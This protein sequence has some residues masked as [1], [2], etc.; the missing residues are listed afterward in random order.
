MKRL[1][2]LDGL[3][4]VLA[5]YV[6]CSHMAPF[7]LLPAWIAHPLSH[8]GAAVDVFFMLSGLVI[9]ESLH[10]FAYRPRPFLTAR[11]ARLYPVFAVVFGFALAVHAL[12]PALDAMPWLAPEGLAWRMWASG[13]S[14]EWP[15]E[16][17][18]H[19]TMTH[20]LFPDGVMP[21]IWVS[22]LGASWSLSTEWQ[23]YALALLLGGMLARAGREPGQV[24]ARLAWLFVALGAAG[25]LWAWL[26]PPDWHF[27]RAFLGNKAH[28]FA[29]GIASV[30]L[31]R[32]GA[33]GMR[34]YGAV[35]LAALAL[36]L[37][38][39]GPVKLLPP[40][41]WTLCVV[42]EL[43]WLPRLQPLAMLL[44]SPPLQWLGAI[45]YGLYLVN[46][47]LQRLLGTVLVGVVAGDGHLF[48]LLW[49]PLA[50]ILPVLAA[51]WL[52]R[53][54]EVP[55]QRLFDRRRAVAARRVGS[56]DG[57]GAAWATA[58]LR[59]P[60]RRQFEPTPDHA[61]RH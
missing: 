60:G 31:I 51:A 52:H 61:K 33:A 3:R 56:A 34:H 37:A 19:L 16:V 55:G 5:V 25:A 22:L 57:R 50:T 58:P 17:L 10:R 15:I 42:A 11:A 29:V 48:T 28:Y 26:T 36:C 2:C 38:Q 54:V 20:G 1:E 41:I 24:A 39:G 45:S 8:G 49:L 53:W 43:A 32:H 40:L 14:A 30:Q 13:W 44:R 12:P 6:M 47:P 4:G 59:P 21:H 27:S 9:V 23:F 18:A 46:E 35:L 7:A